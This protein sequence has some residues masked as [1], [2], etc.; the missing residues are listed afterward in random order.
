M[1]FIF[2]N[3]YGIKNNSPNKDIPSNNNNT[4]NKDIPNN[5]NTPKK[6]YQ[7]TTKNNTENKNDEQHGHH[8]NMIPCYVSL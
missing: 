4:Q 8:Q 1:D 5:N 7:T 2:H 3:S 6:T